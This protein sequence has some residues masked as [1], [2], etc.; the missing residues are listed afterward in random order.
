MS[1]FVLSGLEQYGSKQGTR[2]KDSRI[3][4]IKIIVA[5]LCLLLLIEGVLYLYLIPSMTPG[6]IVWSGLSHYSEKEV[7]QIL[8]PLARNTW[9]KFDREEAYSVLAS[10]PGIEDVRIVKRFPDHIAIQI[11]ERTPVALTFTTVG[12][13]TVPVQIDKNGVLFPAIGGDAESD[14]SIPLISGIPVENIPEGM[15]I[16][17]R[18]RSLIDQ[19]TL[20]SSLKQN[21]FAAVSEIHVVPKEYGSYELVLYPLHSRT[22]ILTDRSLN[23]EA[24]QYMMVMLDVVNSIEPNVTEIDL[25]Y[26]SV[27][28]RT[29]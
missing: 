24:L 20:I 23:V 15:R 1:D 19:I 29:R 5:A 27:S 26:G 4:L 28:Y 18:Y 12:D 16:P 9:M 11:K 8:G 10:V 17:V 7:T 14:N 13:H 25:R 6:R 21:Y 22:R 2:K 3:L